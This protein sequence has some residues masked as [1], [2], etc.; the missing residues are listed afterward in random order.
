MSNGYPIGRARVDN[1]DE[2]GNGP[3]RLRRVWAIG[4]ILVQSL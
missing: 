2:A 4:P 3:V 1:F